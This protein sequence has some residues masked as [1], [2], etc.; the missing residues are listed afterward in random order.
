MT[1]Q[2]FWQP[3][4]TIY[5][6]GEAKAVAR[7][8][9]ET[10]YGLTMSDVILGKVE[11]VPEQELTALQRRLLTGEPVQYVL[12]ETAFCGHRF[13]VGPGVLIPRPETE[14]LCRLF[15]PFLTEKSTTPKTLLDI[16]TGSGC[17]A[18]TA[19]LV[20]ADYP[21][22]VT[23]WDISDDALRLARA[24]AA[25]LGARVNFERQDAL[26]PPHDHDCW[27]FIVSNPPYI[28]ESEKS[29]MESN[30][31]DH[32]PP[33]ALFV[34]DDDPLLFYRAIGRYAQQSLKPGG[35]LFFELNARYG[36]AAASLLADMGFREIT[37]IQDSSH[38]TRFIS[39]CR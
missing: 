10:R 13:L 23:A 19:A 15:I 14:E 1:Y 30:V 7:L 24:N 6:Q 4:T 38:K 11:A 22:E 18:C 39:A 34:P 12:G 21:T 2:E 35:R 20:P 37:T 36:S 16:G 26:H 5:E 17:I 33:L 28:C 29:T 32:E 3:L 27:D 31:L 9:L 25:A 8:V